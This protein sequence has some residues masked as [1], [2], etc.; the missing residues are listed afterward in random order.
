MQ[1]NEEYEMILQID[2]VSKYFKALKAVNNVTFGISKGDL[3]GLIGPNG[4]GK[5]TLFNIITGFLVPEMGKISFKEE[6]ITGLSPHR[7]ARKRI[8]VAFQVSNIFPGLTAFQNIQVAFFASL[9]KTKN[10]YSAAKKMMREETNGILETV[11]LSKLAQTPSESLSQPDKK[12][13]ELGMALS[14][15]PELLLLDEPTSGQSTEETFSTMELIKEIND[16]QGLTILFVEHKMPVVFSIA[17]RIIVLHHGS[18]IADGDP[19]AIR[20][21]KE[22]Q[23]AYLGESL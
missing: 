19:G 12:R 20:K 2:N 21:N 17:Q 8:G 5:S 6:D 18:I 23:K 7:I 4:A 13:L 3:V 9:G 14:G 16:K 10:I 22:V 11:R 1:S 15:K